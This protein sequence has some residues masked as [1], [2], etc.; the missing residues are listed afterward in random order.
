M[1]QHV[2]THV[3]YFLYCNWNTIRHYGEYS[4]TPL[5]GTYFEIKHSAIS[6]HPGL[7]MPMLSNLI[8]NTFR[9]ESIQ[10][11]NNDWVVRK[12]KVQVT[13]KKMYIPDFDFVQKITSYKTDNLIIR[14]LHCICQYSEVYGLPC[15]HSLV[16]TSPFK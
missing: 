12:K 6:T 16:V 1:C 4:K 13:S 14:Q 3:N 10:I 11:S 8:A 2:I 5:E 7:S 9:Y 15:V